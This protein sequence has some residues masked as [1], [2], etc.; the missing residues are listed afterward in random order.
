MSEEIMPASTVTPAYASLED[1]EQEYALPA[2][3]FDLEL[4]SGKVV[5]AIALA[6]TSAILAVEKH[7][8]I[9]QGMCQNAPTADVKPYLPADP[10]VIRMCIYLE[11]FITNPKKSYME[12]MRLSKTTGLL[13]PELFGKLDA[14]LRTAKAEAFIAET[15][16]AKNG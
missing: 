4:E 12:W 16:E 2:E 14:K 3:P 13:I 9:V 1:L 10:D 5:Q 8:K 15:D 7:V 6:D 11:R